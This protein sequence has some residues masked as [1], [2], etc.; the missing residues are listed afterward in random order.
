LE[1]EGTDRVVK[2]MRSV[3]IPVVAVGWKT[4]AGVVIEMEALA[5]NGLLVHLGPAED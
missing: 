3:A 5:E 2:M 4:G 1:T